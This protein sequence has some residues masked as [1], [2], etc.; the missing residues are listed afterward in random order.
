MGEFKKQAES[1]Y[2]R[3][4]DNRKASNF[5]ASYPL[6]PDAIVNPFTLKASKDEA[7]KLSSEN[8]I[9][10]G[11]VRA[12]VD[13]TIGAGLTPQSTISSNIL[14]VNKKKISKNAQIIEEYWNLWASSKDACDFMG[15]QTL[16]EMVRT[17]AFNAYST[18][19]VLQFIGVHKWQGVYVPVVR[20]YDGRSVSNKD[21]V[22]S[23]NEVVSGVHLDKKGRVTGYTIKTE[24]TALDYEFQDVKRYVKYPDSQ[25]DRLQYNLILTGKIQPNQKRGRPLVLPAMNDIIMLGKFNEAEVVKAVIHSYITVFV[26]IDKDMAKQNLD[27]TTNGDAFLGQAYDDKK[28]G[29]S[30]TIDNPITM[31]PGYIQ[32]LLPG[33]KA[34][35]PES[36]SPVADF[37]KFMEGQLKMICMS[38]GQPYEVVLQVFNSNYSASQ[39]AIQAAARGWDIERR[40]FAMQAMQPIYELMVSLLVYQGII[41]CPGYAD[42]PFIRAA[43]NNANWYGP[44]VLS[45]DPVK[46]ATA[47]TLRL[48]NM[49]STYEKECRMLGE[50]F[51]KLVE[52]RSE[53][54]ELLR[55][56]GLIPN[57]T[58]DKKNVTPGEDG[59]KGDKDE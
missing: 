16:G 46:N 43:W 17:A 10:S 15:E 19:D 9:G 29:E 42:N 40:S 48:N 32:R 59:E 37:W 1:I 57:L 6:N 3:S 55:S 52:R 14:N 35:L 44:V 23:T 47:A 38:T 24:K 5:R 26:E 41:N 18:G 13:G 51:D 56:L 22:S 28:A 21:G 31:G 20:F 50:D 2:N 36:K 54:D 7:L 11:L 27:T 12:M 30:G 49:T 8:A 58:V 4:D 25:L 33:E 45:I 34:T 53:E 39:A